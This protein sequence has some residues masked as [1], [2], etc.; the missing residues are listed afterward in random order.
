M[1]NITGEVTLKTD[2]EIHCIRYGIAYVLS[3]VSDVECCVIIRK[4]LNSIV[5]IHT[6]IENSDIQVFSSEKL[7]TQ[8]MTHLS[9]WGRWTLDGQPQNGSGR[10]HFLD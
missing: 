1:K 3:S 2:E 10:I 9:S 7:R 8:G 4:Q 5:N 6:P